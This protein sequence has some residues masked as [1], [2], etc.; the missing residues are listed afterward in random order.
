MNLRG[1]LSLPSSGTATPRQ[2]AVFSGNNEGFDAIFVALKRSRAVLPPVFAV[3]ER[4]I[5]SICGA[6]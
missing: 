4:G 1:I 3:F 5:S 6:R 2:L